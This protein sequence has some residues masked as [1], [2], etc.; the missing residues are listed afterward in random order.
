MAEAISYASRFFLGGE[1]PFGALRAFS[2]EEAS[3]LIRFS[4]DVIA[5]LRH[6]ADGGAILADLADVLRSRDWTRAAGRSEA[7]QTKVLEGL[8]Q[9]VARGAEDDFKRAHGFVTQIV[10]DFGKDLT[11]ELKQL[12]Q[13]FR[14]EAAAEATK[15]D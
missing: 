7:H 1:S 8:L 5:D 3:T 15:A 9:S 11:D 2:E 14:G 10:S 13:H 4:D 6:R 12:L